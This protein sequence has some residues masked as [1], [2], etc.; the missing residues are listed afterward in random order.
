[1]HDAQ[2]RVRVN[3]ARA[4]AAIADPAAIPALFGALEDESVLVQHWAEAGL[5]KLGVGT[6]Y[7][8]P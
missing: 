4:L 8:A 6:V 2:P 3:A 5:E 7:F 1:M